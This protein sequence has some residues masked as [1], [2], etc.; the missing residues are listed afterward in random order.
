MEGRPNCELQGS[1]NCLISKIKPNL[2]DFKLEIR[3]SKL[4]S[5][6]WQMLGLRFTVIT[7]GSYLIFLRDR[8]S[9]EQGLLPSLLGSQRV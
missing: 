5:N 4:E 9:D 1:G 2:V 8:I 6:L 3:A 7:G